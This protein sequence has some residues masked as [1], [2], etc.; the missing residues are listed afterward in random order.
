MGF[1]PGKMKNSQL[2]NHKTKKGGMEMALFDRT[3]STYD[4]WCNTSLGS[5][6]DQIEKNMIAEFAQPKTGEIA[7]DLG[8][9]TGI[10]TLWL[11]QKGL[12]VTGIDISADMLQQTKQKAEREK[13]RVNL[14]KGNIHE[15]P[16]LK[17]T[18]DL[19]ISNI[20]L[21]FVH[22]P[23]QVV[24]EALRVLKKDG[25]LVIGMIHRD[26]YWGKKYA[27]KGKQ[28]QKSVFASAQFYSEETIKSWEPKHF[29]S[30]HY[31]L[32]ITPE[33]FKGKH[34]ALKLEKNL[35]KSDQTERASY[36]VA[37]WGK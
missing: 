13:L 25:R 6:V 26:G 27:I 19:V 35:S 30:I 20:V 12:H 23:I 4:N 7:L 2:S 11:A 36:I 8:C 5:T 24:S 16:F 10:Y 37:K 15:L 28:D 34:H 21:E 31:G 17:D 14:L 1:G 32:Y 9:G 18:F 29:V 33:N 3:S 22:D